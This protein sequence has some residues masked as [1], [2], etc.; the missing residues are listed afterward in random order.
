MRA[1]IGVVSGG[2]IAL[3]LAGCE[4]TSS[5]DL[6][7]SGIDAEIMVSAQSASLSQIT[8][9]LFPGGDDDPFNRVD[10]Q[11]GDTLWAEAS[12]QHKLL[13]KSSLDYG[14]SLG[15]GAGD[16][17]F[18][19]GLDR[20]SPDVDAVN[21][22]GTLPTPFD[23]AALAK[24]DFARSETIAVTWAPSGSTDA[25]SLALYGDCIEGR[26]FSITGDPGTYALAPGSFAV[27]TAAA[28]ASCPVQITIRRQRDGT[29]DPALNSESSFTLEQVRTTSFNTTPP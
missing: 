23:I 1:L 4:H 15:V 13:G 8:V 25:M 11:G 20:P 7:T 24:T 17:Q 6:K 27:R 12:G 18:R 28:T 14:T 21:S 5:R 26:T 19:L 2:L 10:L 3:S 9:S 22:L 29:V 16:T